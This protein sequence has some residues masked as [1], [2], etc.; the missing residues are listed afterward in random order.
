[1][2]VNNNL[3]WQLLFA[4]TSLCR[5]DSAPKIAKCGR[6]RNV[7]MGHYE[8]YF[9]IRDYHDMEGNIILE[10]RYLPNVLSD[11]YHHYYKSST[12]KGGNFIDIKDICEKHFGPEPE[13]GWH[14]ALVELDRG[15]KS[16]CVRYRIVE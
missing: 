13:E 3:T 9:D 2:D 1:M 8:A 11:P 16:E 12:K 7:N 5:P 15:E 6:L 10:V 4:Q 14:Y